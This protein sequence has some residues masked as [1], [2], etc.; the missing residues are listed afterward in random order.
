MQAFVDYVARGL[1]DQPEAV[2]VRE[3]RWRDRAVYH[4]TVAEGDMGKVIGKGGRIAQ[5]MRTVL[6]AS[7]ARDGLRV[8]LDIG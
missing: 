8:T 3:E 6:K 1:V 4:L 5:A 7:G 2:R